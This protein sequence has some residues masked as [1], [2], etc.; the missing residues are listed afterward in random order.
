MTNNLSFSKAERLKSKKTLARLFKEGRSFS[1]YPVRVVWLKEETPR[2]V[3]LQFTVSVPK[4]KFKNAVD[5]NRIKRQIREA[6]RLN[7][8]A[9]IEKLSEKQGDKE[10]F[11]LMMIYVSTDKEAYAKIDKAVGKCLARLARDMFK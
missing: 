1:V 2:V 6:Y 9:L 11:A 10:S 4:K 8:S 7:K 5:R 3:P